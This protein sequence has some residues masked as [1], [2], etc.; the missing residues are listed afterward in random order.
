MER[1]RFDIPGFDLKIKLNSSET[2]SPEKISGFEHTINNL[3]GELV[4]E[5]FEVSATVKELNTFS[6]SISAVHNRGI[7]AYQISFDVGLFKW[8]YDSLYVVLSNN[9]IFSGFGSSSGRF[10]IPTLD[11]PD[12]NSLD[13]AMA[14]NEEVLFDADRLTLHGYLYT[15]CLSFIIR[16]EVRHIANGHVDYLHN[17]L[18]P[19][20]YENSRNGLSTMDNQ[21]LE[22]DVDSCVFVGILH[23]MLNDSSQKER[24][25]EEL[26]DEMGVFMSALFCIQ[27][28]FYC[29]P[30]RKATSIAEAEANSHPNAYLRYF[31]SFTA[32]LSYIEEN[33]PNHLDAFGNLHKENFWQFINSVFENDSVQLEKIRLDYDWSNSQEGFDYMNR[34]WDNWNSWIPRLQRF[35][36]LPLAS[37]T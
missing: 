28:L 35:T 10:S 29:L 2:C 15:L 9:D 30:S 27:F 12:W 19:L 18:N 24:I 3:I 6:I 20:F 26:R 1:L 33:W 36:Y 21:T 4:T 11:V 5:E 32:G 23:G 31:F 14:N 34:I 22:M 17:E 8:I 13:L 25:P 7:R 16:H 37:S